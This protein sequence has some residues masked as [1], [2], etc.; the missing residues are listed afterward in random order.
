MKPFCSHSTGMLLKA[1]SN[2]CSLEQGPAMDALRLIGV[3]CSRPHGGHHRRDDKQELDAC[4][5]SGHL[6]GLILL[7]SGLL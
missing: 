4:L 2:V 1:N 3:A 6:H 5:F 7:W